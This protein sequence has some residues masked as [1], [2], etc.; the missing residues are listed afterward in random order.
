MK[1]GLKGPAQLQDC[2]IVASEKTLIVYA[3]EMSLLYVAC[4]STNCS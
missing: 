4:T 2:L 3:L 1:V